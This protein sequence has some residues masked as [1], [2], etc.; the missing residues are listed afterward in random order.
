M[1]TV[2][3]RVIKIVAEQLGV[4]EEEVNVDKALVG[5]LGADDEDLYALESALE[6]E[7]EI[8]FGEYDSHK[9]G[10]VQGAVHL[11]EYHRARRQD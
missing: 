9:M 1:S 8:E 2:K 4:K 7:F 11:V 6:E 10:T 5:D 3:E